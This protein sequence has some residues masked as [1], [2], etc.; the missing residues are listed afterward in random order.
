M[1][2]AV[3]DQVR[4]THCGTPAPKRTVASGDW[5]CCPG[6]ATAYEILQGC[7]LGAYYRLRD[8]LGGK[9]APVRTST[10][11]YIELD[12]AEVQAGFVRGAPGGLRI[13][14][15]RLQGLSCAACVWLIERIMEREAAVIHARVDLTRSRVILTWDPALAPLST[16]ARQLDRLG[17]A[18]EPDTS[19]TRDAARR[20]EDRD[21]WLRLGVAGAATGNLMLLAAPEYLDSLD[22]VGNLEPLFRWASLLVALPLMLYAAAPFTRTAWAGLKERV[23]HMD[24]PIALALWIAFTGSAMSVIRGRGEVF[25]DSLGMLTFL[26]LLGRLLVLQGRRRAER[27]AEALLKL[28][29]PTARIVQADGSTV[30]VAAERVRSGD[31]I[32]VLPGEAPAADGLVREGHA[33]I[34]N[35]VLTGESLPIPVGPG[36]SVVAGAIVLD[37]PL[38]IEATAVGRDRR[39][40]QIAE[41]AR[42]AALQRAPVVRL[43]DRLAGAFSGLTL[44][45][46]AL[47]LWLWWDHGT[48][49]AITHTVAVAVVLCPCA[50]GLATSFALAIAH[51]RAARLGAM[52]KGSDSI[53]ALAHT[54]IIVLDKTGTLTAGHPRLLAWTGMATHHGHSVL[55]IV[56][57]IE[58]HS[59]HPLGRAFVEAASSD[60]ATIS[61]SDVQSLPGRGVRA[62]A[63]GHTWAIGNAALLGE[64]QLPPAWAEQAAPVPG[65]TRIWIACDGRV[66]AGA[67]VA[68]PLAPGAAAAVAA[69]H[70]RGLRTVVLS[71]DQA[72]AVA[73]VADALGISEYHAGLSPEAK[74]DA[75]RE[76]RHG[77]RVAMVG[78]GVN[79][80]AALAA[81]D[82]GIAVAGSAEAALAAADAYVVR[83]GLEA[84]VALVDTARGALQAIRRNIAMGAVYNV[85]GATLAMRGVIGPLEA[86]IFMPLSSLTV[87]AS[88]FLGG[89]RR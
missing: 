16:L 85:V 58:R 80:A 63:L 6:C 59:L 36:D 23:L 40:A 44:G 25:F 55:D 30:E 60:A 13:A 48:A 54:R 72:P 29:A 62:R 31:V 34:D 89:R 77:G 12:D 8:Q 37:A 7:D 73:A 70:A 43:A 84:V 2:N 24:L 74:L 28:S 49:T 39:L 35:H 38:L 67:W 26:L 4:C 1:R 87:L 3:A 56:A 22:L 15:L 45:L 10:R 20:R 81:A 32:R 14:A 64:A 78:D 71:G 33:R 83:G 9:G 57:A 69:L 47:T 75:I 88:S 46:A 61:V 79:D 65:A 27:A 53:E 11:S 51:G 41:L 68:D 19:D 52:V 42:G 66:V 82:A 86:A 21:L 17:Y 18:P 76:L 50:L 5:F